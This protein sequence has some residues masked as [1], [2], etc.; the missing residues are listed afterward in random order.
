MRVF[1]GLVFY[2]L[3]SLCGLVVVLSRVV[4]VLGMLAAAAIGT[5]SL[6]G[7]SEPLAAGRHLRSEFVPGVPSARALRHS[8]VAI[9]SNRQ[10]AGL[11][12]LVGIGFGLDVARNGSR[13]LIPGAPR[14]RQ[15]FCNERSTHG[16][17]DPRGAANNASHEVFNLLALQSGSDEVVS[18]ILRVDR[19]LHNGMFPCNRHANRPREKAR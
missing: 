12:S 1:R 17:H 11:L 14:L 4:S 3:L 18:G 2:P 15:E 13:L 19:V 7:P 10:D 16:T 9:E 6:A 8:T 5:G